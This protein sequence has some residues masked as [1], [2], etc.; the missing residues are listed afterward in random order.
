MSLISKKFAP[1]DKVRKKKY[2]EK[3]EGRNRWGLGRFTKQ[4]SKHIL[5]ID[6]IPKQFSKSANIKVWF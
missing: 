4:V 2:R 5:N 3:R 6:F 1:T